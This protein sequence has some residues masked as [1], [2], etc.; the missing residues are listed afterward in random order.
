MGR[1]AK[2]LQGKP[3]RK[4]QDLFKDNEGLNKLLKER[5]K[6]GSKQLLKNTLL[7]KTKLVEAGSKLQQYTR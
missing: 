6:A 4:H 2:K 1:A 3:S 7:N 5:N